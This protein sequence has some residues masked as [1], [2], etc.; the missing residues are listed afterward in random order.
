[1]PTS[2]KPVGVNIKEKCYVIL[3]LLIIIINIIVIILTFT[4]IKRKTVQEMLFCAGN[5]ISISR[6]TSCCSKVKRA[7][8]QRSVIYSNSN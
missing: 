2:T 5:M 3:L 6:E 1:M 4:T 7:D 8:V